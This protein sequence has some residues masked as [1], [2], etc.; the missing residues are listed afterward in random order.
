MLQWIRLQ[1]PKYIKTVTAVGVLLV[2]V[3]CIFFVGS[4]TFAQ[5]SANLSEGLPEVGRQT[6][7]SSDLGQIITRI[8]NVVFGILGI[9]I[10]LLFFYAGFLWMTARGNEEQVDTAK[11]IIKN[12][13]IGAVVVLLSYSL[14]Q[15]I[16]Y[17]LGVNRGGPGGL[18]GGGATVEGG[19]FEGSGALG[20]IIKDHYPTRDQTEVPRNTKIIITFRKPIKMDSI[21]DNTNGSKDKDG[22]ELFGD[23]VN[24]GESMNWKTDC[25]TLRLDNEHIAITRISDGERISGASVLASYQ[26][27]QVYSI[28]IRPHES[29]GSASEKIGYKVRIGKEV[30]LD[31]ASNG[32]P[33]IFNSQVSGR[34]YYEWQ[35]TCSTALDV[36]PPVVQS[37]FPGDKA[38]EAKNT[39]IQ[40]DFSEAMDPTGLQGSFA[41][42]GSIFKLLDGV[43]YL[44]SGSS[45]V[46]V[47]NFVL[48]NGYRT[49]EFASTK[50]CGV[51]S[52]GNTLFCLPVCDRAGANCKQDTY[53]LLVKAARTFSNDAF[54][55]VPFSGA[56]DIAGNA[57][58]GNRNGK[59]DRAPTTGSV[60][61]DQEKPDNYSWSFS[62]K[63]VIDNTA[64][65][66]RQM[67][68]GIDA[69][70]IA[71]S[72]EWSMTFSKRMRA[73]SLYSIGIDQKPVDPVPLCR[74]PRATFATDGTT[75]VEM[76]HCAFNKDAR[77]YY[78]P[79]ITSEVEDVHYNCFYPG[80]GPGGADEVG[81]RQKV[82]SVCDASG[83][84]C[85][86]ISS[87]TPSGAFC[88]N[89][90]VSSK[91]NST[92]SCVQFLKDNSL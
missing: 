56:M 72:D 36:V 44:R 86:E 65:F 23:C 26:N 2:A 45:T 7:L 84:N 83:K 82:S 21:A 13:I 78:F 25:D 1:F 15:G 61:P 70:F 85:C 62:I 24:V 47:G 41:T 11:R 50:A 51:N 91:Q 20:G 53:E 54:E 71:P 52:C 79:V 9:L 49:L 43:I 16:L 12:A 31:D 8:V 39:V 34:D 92:N 63:D 17:L 37:V 46:P 48:T 66:L 5:T 35:F 59:V 6:G 30:L 69:Q 18:G 4:H 55:S 76:L 77:V 89:G 3:F 81:R 58:D 40:V 19:N 73:D 57:L 42:D 60:F 68:P 74:A 22:K 32:N 38:V 90:V 67:T 87:S 27:G 14:A 10:F 75:K 88:C 64:P 33:P 29:L 28:V 80:K